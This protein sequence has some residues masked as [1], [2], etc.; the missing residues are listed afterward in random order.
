MKIRLVRIIVFTSPGAL[1]LFQDIRERE[2]L[3]YKDT[4]RP[5][6]SAEV[7][8]MMYLALYGRPGETLK[9][10]QRTPSFRRRKRERESDR[11]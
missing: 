11:G 5:P 10:T 2:C 7:E 6:A 1:I 9:L 3:K 8:L 4:F